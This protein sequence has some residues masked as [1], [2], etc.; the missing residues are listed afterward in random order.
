MRDSIRSRQMFVCSTQGNDSGALSLHFTV[1]DDKASRR[2][3]TPYYEDG[4]FPD[5]TCVYVCR[6]ESPQNPGTLS[7]SPQSTA[8]FLPQTYEINLPP[9]P[10]DG[11]PAARFP[12]CVRHDAGWFDKSRHRPPCA[13]VRQLTGR[14]LQG[15]RSWSKSLG[16]WSPWSGARG[17]AP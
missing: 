12:R 9:E 11:R 2:R 10:S 6:R 8:T 13:R 1:F 17:R 14:P 5:V 7:A 16:T 4:C 15:P 3:E